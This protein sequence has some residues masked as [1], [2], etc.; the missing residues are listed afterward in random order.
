MNWRILY[1]R[2][3]IYN[4]KIYLWYCTSSTFIVQVI[5]Q[6]NDPQGGVQTMQDWHLSLI[7]MKWTQGCNYHCICRWHNG[8]RR[9]TRIDEYN[10]FHQEIICDYINGGTQGLQRMHNQALTDHDEPQYLSTISYYQDDSRIQQRCKI[11]YD[12]QYPRCNI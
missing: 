2:K 11:T 10:L 6:D 8:N 1:M 4:D 3:Y 5:Y 7:Q 12:I 9:Q